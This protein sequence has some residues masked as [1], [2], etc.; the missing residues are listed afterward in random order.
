MCEDQAHCPDRDLESWKEVDARNAESE[1]IADEFIRRLQMLA[2]FVERIK[3]AG[4][5]GED[6]CIACKTGTL[7]WSVAPSNRHT[8]VV[9]TTDD[10]LNWIE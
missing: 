4:G 3:A 10:C 8:R 5:S 9:C 7:R 1:A 6:P 2:P